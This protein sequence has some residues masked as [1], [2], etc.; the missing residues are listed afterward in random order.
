VHLV[1]GGSVATF[2]SWGLVWWTPTFLQRSHHLTVGEAGKLLG[3]AH[4]I[5]GTASTLLAG[6]LMSLPQARDPRFVARLLAAVTAVATLPSILLYWVTSDL[7]ATVLLWVFVPAVYFFIGPVLGLLQNVMPANMRASTCAIL[8]FTANV[9][10]LIL[11]PQL[12]GWLSVWFAGAYG[13]G[14]EQSLRWAL[15]LLAVTGFWA[16]AHLWVAGNTIRADEARA[17]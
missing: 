8:L 9:A 17:T 7:A 3:L 13:A 12:I 1:V 10:N 2:W 15:L 14:E 11:A 5:A 4:L 16:A 6:L